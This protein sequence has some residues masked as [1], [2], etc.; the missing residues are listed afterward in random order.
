MA[1]QQVLKLSPAEEILFADK[2]LEQRA[3][4]KGIRKGKLEG[5]LEG[6][7]EGKLEG[8]REGIRKGT[9][10]TL[11]QQLEQRFGA[12]PAHVTTRLEA[13]TQSELEEMALR[14]LSA[15]TLDDVVGKPKRSPP[16]AKRT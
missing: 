16:K 12:L 9:L 4:R 10:G 1:L 3:F 6:M 11:S 5:K 13:A 2:V 15:T 8:T 7:R 14:I